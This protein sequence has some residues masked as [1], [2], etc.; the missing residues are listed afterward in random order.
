MKTITQFEVRHPKFNTQI[1]PNMARAEFA[2][3]C[4]SSPESITIHEVQVTE[5]EHGDV[6][7]LELHRGGSDDMDGIHTGGSWT[8]P[9]RGVVKIHGEHDV[10]VVDAETGRHIQTINRI[11]EDHAFPYRNVRVV[12]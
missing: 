2:K 10:R 9:V 1:H 12:N 7:E 3:S 11:A 6:V 5:L 8:G 4:S